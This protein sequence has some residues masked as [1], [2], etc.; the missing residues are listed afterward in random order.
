M[1]VVVG[2]RL[3]VPGMDASIII[4]G[5]FDFVESLE[6]SSLLAFLNDC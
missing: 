1:G 2:Y 5:L 3:M 6:V 4:D